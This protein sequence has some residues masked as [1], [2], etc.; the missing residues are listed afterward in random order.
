MPNAL[1]VYPKFPPSYWGAQ[2]ALEFIGKKSAMPPLGLLTVAGMFPSGYQL[3]V[4]DMNVDPL[5]EEHL[6]W[7]DMVFTST[8][9]VQK[10]SLREVIER[11]KRAQV[12]VIAGG[13][14]PTTFYEEID[15]VDHFVLDEVEDTFGEFLKDFEKGRAQRIYRSSAKPSIKDAPLPRYDLINI[16]TYGSMALQFSRGCPFDCEF[17]DITKLFGRV[18]RTKSAEQILAEFDVLYNL[19]WRGRMFLVDDNFIG[20]KRDAMHVLPEIARWQK[21][22]NYPFSLY[23]EASVNLSGLDDLLDA[24]VDAGF[25]MAFLG[26]ETPNREALLKTKKAQNTHRHDDNFLLNAVRKIQEKG[27][28][29]TAGFI[30]GL[31][32]DGEEAF[33]AQIEFIQQAGIPTAMV[34]LLSALKG[35]DLYKRLQN[36]GRLLEESSGNNVSV[37]LN[38]RTEMDHEVLIQGY[39]RVLS[40]LYDPGL[41]NYFGR[42]LTMLQRVKSR[43]HVTPKIGKAEWMALAKS[44]KR[45][46][47]SRQGPA[48]LKFLLTVLKEKPRVFSDAVRLAI[49]GY[50]FEKT[51]SQQIAVDDFKRYLEAEFE[52]FKQALSRIA[53]SEMQRIAEIQNSVRA[54]LYRVH[55]KYDQIH[56]DFRYCLADALDSFKR[57]VESQIEELSAGSRLKFPT[58]D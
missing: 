4:V 22:R 6:E 15:G 46:L 11:A 5:T 14:H 23:T 43:S 58:T 27:L 50:H 30:L 48:Y 31:D 37:S 39:K 44:L 20:N 33:D 19:G 57:S 18:P 7:A 8:M 3:K 16:H 32:S 26:I 56:E 28:E 12:P 41:K 29:V 17:C 24:M 42:C 38:F 25:T 9:I 10:D 34:G 35:T 47:L 21:A 2:Y 13:P 54:L 40:T 1:L 45:Q 52:F 49:L 51:T 55:L 36:E 53:T